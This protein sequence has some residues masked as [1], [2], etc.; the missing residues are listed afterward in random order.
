LFVV[1]PVLLQHELQPFW[2]LIGDKYGLRIQL[3]LCELQPLPLPSRFSQLLLV[4]RTRL[5]LVTIADLLLLSTKTHTRTFVVRCKTKSTSP[6]QE[7]NDDTRNTKDTNKE[8]NCTPTTTTTT[9]TGNLLSM[10][11]LYLPPLA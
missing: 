9:T 7:T 2:F 3:F 10:Q 4:I 6:V 11:V 8:K 5:I 1:L